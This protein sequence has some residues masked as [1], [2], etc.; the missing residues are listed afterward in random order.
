MQAL[1]FDDD[2]EEELDVSCYLVL[3]CLAV[4]LGVLSLTLGAS[5]A[6]S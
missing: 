3:L 5:A 2:E 4:Q 1:V 6:P